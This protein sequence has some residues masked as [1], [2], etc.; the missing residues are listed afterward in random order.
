MTFLNP[1]PGRGDW[2]G[3]SLAIYEN[4]LVIGAEKD[5][6]I[7]VEGGAAYLFDGSTGESYRVIHTSEIG[8]VTRWLWMQNG[9]R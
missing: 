7:V 6:D 8:S 1:S 3:Y 9:S 4:L 5:S 2:F